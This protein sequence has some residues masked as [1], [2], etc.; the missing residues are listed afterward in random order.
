MSDSNHS[1]LSPP[2]TMTPLRISLIVAQGLNRVIGCNN[3]MP[4]HIPE[5]LQYFK[6]TTMGKPVIM[7][8]KT[9]DSI[10]RPLPKRPNIVVTRQPEWQADGVKVT[11]SLEQALSLAPT[12]CNSSEIMII[13]GAEIYRQALPLANRLYIT[14]IKAS[15]E[16]D[17]FFPEWDVTE[18]KRVLPDDAL[19]AKG[20]SSVS[21]LEY[22]FQVFDRT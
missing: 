14:Q 16:G 6:R 11:N 12:M 18:W 19:G 3:S 21:N 9:F 1:S 22:E 13:G 10:G 2:Q 17:A 20:V 4:W 15:F 8:R 5:D 7:G